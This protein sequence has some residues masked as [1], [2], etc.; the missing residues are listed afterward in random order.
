MKNDLKSQ[1]EK[2]MVYSDAFSENTEVYK[3]IEQINNLTNTNG[4]SKFS[5]ENYQIYSVIDE[6]EPVP[7]L[8]VILRTQGTREQ[9]LREAL[10]SLRS[11]VN[12]NFEVILIAHKA[13]D[14]AK[15]LIKSII[16]QQPTD[17][18]S[19]IR[20]IELDIGTRTTP[21]NVGCACARGQYI[22]IFDDD[23]L[24]FDNWVDCYEQAAKE[25]DGQIL[26]AYVLAQRW[27]ALECGYMATDAPTS[28][29]C[30]NFDF[31]SQLVVNK[32]PLMGLAFPSYLYKKLG[33]SFNEELN[34]TEDWEFFMRVVSMTGIYDI[35]EPTSI[36]R[37]WV[38]AESSYTLHSEKLWNETYQTIQGYMDKRSLLIP[39]GYTKHLISLIQRV[40][41]QDKNVPAAF[42]KLNGYLYYGENG[43]SNF[44]DERMVQC[45][46]QIHS[47]AFLMTFDLPEKYDGTTFFRF[48]PCEY[49]GIILRDIEINMTTDAGENIVYSLADCSHNGLD[50]EK[51]VYFMHY[52]PQIIWNYHGGAKI[53]SIAVSGATSMEIPENLIM[54]TIRQESKIYRVKRKILKLPSKVRDFLKKGD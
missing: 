11:Q 23:D 10:L 31:L 29:F 18:A 37:L 41:D 2:L 33:F 40:N 9:G 19:K 38:N 42:P 27:K 39:S 45:Y 49:G 6:T 8:S 46:N 22:S 35:Q 30:E 12:Q 47:P 1:L 7:F 16:Q 43:S 25:H 14:E 4:I 20:Y 13:K 51:G 48:D 21:I 28:Q 44:A 3:F 17:F 34:V 54:E 15:T 36:Y 32:C 50:W 52:D 53:V 24:L 26:H 5:L